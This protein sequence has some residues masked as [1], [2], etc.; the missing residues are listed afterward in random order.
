MKRKNFILF[1]L[2]LL[3]ITSQLWAQR[4]RSPYRPMET[5]NGDTVQY[6]EFNYTI[7]STQYKGLTVG[8]I[9]RELEY[10]VLYVF[11]PTVTHYTS[12][13]TPSK[14]SAL[15][16]VIRQ[17]GK[18]PSIGKDYYITVQFE[19]PVDMDK[20]SEVTGKNR[21]ALFTLKL[22][23][24]FKDLRV[25]GVSTNEFIIKDPELIERALHRREESRQR[26]REMK[27][28]LK[29]RGFDVDYFYSK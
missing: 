5:F 29:R 21:P 12:G 13:N 17:T 28:E 27:E 4:E 24:F 23:D 6:L 14:L 8:E 15:S 1:V 10:P 16:F 26:S 20:Y 19:T 7:R 3:L 25:S 11:N 2:F 9:L 22:Y 18:E